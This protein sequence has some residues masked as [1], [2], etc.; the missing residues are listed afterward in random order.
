[1]TMFEWFPIRAFLKE[2]AT[3]VRTLGWPEW[4]AII[5]M[6]LLGNSALWYWQDAFAPVSDDDPAMIE[7]FVN[8]QASLED[9]LTKLGLPAFGGWQQVGL[10]NDTLT[11]VQEPE[12]NPAEEAVYPLYRGGR[13][14]WKPMPGYVDGYVNTLRIGSIDLR[15]EVRKPT[16]C[17]A[18][19]IRSPADTTITA[20]LGCDGGFVLWLNGE[21]L[22]ISDLHEEMRPGQESVRLPLRKGDNRL[23]WRIKLDQQPCR[24]FFQPDFGETQTESLLAELDRAFPLDRERPEAYRELAQ[25]AATSAEDPYYRLTEIP[26]PEVTFIEGGGLGFTP[27][28]KLVVSTRRGF[29][30]LVDGAMAADPSH[31]RF[32]RIASGLHEALGLHIAPDGQTHV[33]ERGG[34]TRLADRDGDGIFDTFQNVCSDW[35]IS[36]DYHE[37]T[38]DLERDPA[39]NF[40]TSLSLPHQYSADGQ[41]SDAPWRGWIVQIAPDGT[42]LPWCYGFRSADG[43]GWNAAGDLFAT[44]N[45]GQ[46]VAASPLYHIRKDHFYGHPASRQWIDDSVSDEARRRATRPPTPPAVW[47]PYEEFCMS[48]TDIVCDTTGGRFGPFENQL[49]VGDMMKG[50]LVRVALEKIDGEYQGACFLFRRGVGA[51]HRMTFG[52]DGRMYLTRAARGWGG[53]GHGEGLARLEFSGNAPLEV[54]AVRLL[55][56]GFEL[57]F[58][59][60]LNDAAARLVGEIRVE[61]FRYEYWGNYGSPKV[62]REL[63]PIQNV[64][65]SANCRRMTVTVRNVKANHICH[66]SLP[67]FA[68]VNGQVLLH[69]DAYYTVNRLNAKGSR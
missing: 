47:I 14:G 17:L 67:R 39:G 21:S 54:R 57:E 41:R 48:A 2:L 18:R 59:A 50:T 12:L 1:M 3:L 29:V 45:Q 33:V 43:L 68:G 15:S 51:V 63:L 53:G 23:V 65:L 36:G 6:I 24:F 8:R 69:T 27:E 60:P 5:A 58:T 61:Q 52:P 4:L 42:M 32:T 66:L 38:L 55:A 31:A 44:D 56:E 20:Y 11:L 34:L 28:G 40:Y 30:Y 19:T 16:V 37:Y 7:L 49:F 26:A 35:G 64:E 10:L 62:D 9:R 46:W 22:L 13:S 25:V